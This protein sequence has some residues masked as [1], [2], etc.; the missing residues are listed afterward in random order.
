MPYD[1]KSD[2]QHRFHQQK[3]QR[4]TKEPAAPATPN[5]QDNPQPSEEDMHEEGDKMRAQDKLPS[6]SKYR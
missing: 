3:Q 1:A 5:T 6:K 2:W 4:R